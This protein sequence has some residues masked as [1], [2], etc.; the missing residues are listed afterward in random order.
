LIVHVRVNHDTGRIVCD[1]IGGNFKSG[2]KTL[3]LGDCHNTRVKIPRRQR[4]VLGWL[5][6]ATIGVN[7]FAEVTIRRAP[8]GTLSIACLGLDSRGQLR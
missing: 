5:A 6:I 4:L 8:S 2:G 1:G 7:G 3:Y